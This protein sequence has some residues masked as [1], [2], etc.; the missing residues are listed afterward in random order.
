MNDLDKARDKVLRENTAQTV[1]KYLE[2]LENNKAEYGSRWIWELVQ[3]ARDAAGKNLRSVVEA[4][5]SAGAF[6]F[7]HSGE[8]FREEEIAHLIYYGS[9]K[10]DPE[11]SDPIGNFGSGFLTT[12]LLAKS[13]SVKGT[14]YDGRQFNFV[15]ERRESVGGS[16]ICGVICRD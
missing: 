2:D 6:V 12:H 14:M 16:R 13:V 3:N 10:H 1:F 7:R 9:S 5:L 8:P 15:L 4:S 11:S